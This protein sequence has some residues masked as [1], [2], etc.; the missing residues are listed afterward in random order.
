[1]TTPGKEASEKQTDGPRHVEQGPDDRRR[2]GCDGDHEADLNNQGKKG[3]RE[4]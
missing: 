4:D 2:L 3:S 1:M